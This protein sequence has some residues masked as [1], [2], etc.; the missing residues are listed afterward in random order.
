[1]QEPEP[2]LCLPPPRLPR[3]HRPTSRPRCPDLVNR[4]HG[5]CHGIEDAVQQPSDCRRGAAADVNLRPCRFLGSSATTT[6]CLGVLYPASRF[7]ACSTISSGVAVVPSRRTTAA[8]TASIHSGC[9]TPN[10]VGRSGGVPPGL[11]HDLVGIAALAAPLQEVL[12]EARD[13]LDEPPDGERPLPRRRV[14]RSRC[15][16]A[17]RHPMTAP[18]DAQIGGGRDGS[19]CRREAGSAQDAR[20]SAWAG[21]RPT[22]V[23]ATDPATTGDFDHGMKPAENDEG[24]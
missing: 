2:G 9:A 1:M 23:L 8:V 18:A 16:S 17:Y 6:T 3:R 11:V 10:T 22:A 4:R 20:G 7:L 19:P 5:R 12:V 13:G 15:R 14:R 21:A 24:P